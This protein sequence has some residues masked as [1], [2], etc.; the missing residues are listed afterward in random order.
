MLSD[1]A[2]GG[3]LEWLF[4]A[5]P[6]QKSASQGVKEVPVSPPQ[7]NDYVKKQVEKMEQEKVEKARKEA[8]DKL[9]KP[10]VR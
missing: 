10:I 5:K 1:E 2:K 9:K 4:G 6:L 7:S 3:I 8:M